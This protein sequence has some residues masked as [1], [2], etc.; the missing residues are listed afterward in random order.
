MN[1]RKFLGLAL[2]ATLGSAAIGS[3]LARPGLADEE[4]QDIA[5]AGA[6]PIRFPDVVLRTQD[7]EEVRFYDDLIKGKIV[8][9]SFIPSSDD[10]YGHL[11]VANLKQLQKVLGQRVGPD[12]FIYTITLDPDL[13]SPELLAGY[14]REFQAE[15]GWLF[16]TGEKAQIESLR[17]FFG[18]PFPDPLAADGDQHIGIVWWGIEPLGRWAASPALMDPREIARHISWAEPDGERPSF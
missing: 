14:A 3:A 4:A 1:R 13:D 12:I 10:H 17:Q 5:L 9:I 15:P 18:I 8:V 11:A 2:G 7:G 16:L 6:G